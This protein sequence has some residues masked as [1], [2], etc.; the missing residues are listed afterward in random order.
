MSAA[1]IHEVFKYWNTISNVRGIVLCGGYKNA[2]GVTEAE[3]MLHDLIRN[4]PD[5]YLY[6]SFRESLL[7]EKNS[8]R[9]HNNALEAMKVI[10]GKVL[11]DDFKIV[12]IDHP[13]HLTRTLLCFQTVNRLWYGGRYK[14]KGLAALEV[15]DKDIPNQPYWASRETWTSREKKT[16]LLY[17]LLL[18]RPWARLGLWI[19][20]TVWPS[21]KQ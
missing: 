2:E 5:L 19:L 7:I 6:P 8:Y 17:K 16:L 20:R 11:L 9:T 10:Y 15:Y 12:V 1:I 4:Y 14:I 3:S 18:F 13:R 21:E